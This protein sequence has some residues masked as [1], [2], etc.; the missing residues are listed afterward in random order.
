MRSG[1]KIR[2]LQA[3]PVGGSI[4]LAAVLLLLTTVPL[5]ASVSA[6]GIRDDAGSGQ[7]APNLPRAEIWIDGGHAYQGNLTGIAG[8]DSDWY[9]LDASGED[10]VDVNV[11]GALVC[12]EITD[13]TGERLDFSCSEAYQQLSQFTVELTESPFHLLHIYYNAPQHYRFAIG[14]N[15]EAT[16]PLAPGAPSLQ[17]DAGSGQDAGAGPIG[18]VPIEPGNSYQGLVTTYGDDVEDWYSFHAQAGETIQAK[19]HGAVGC[20][21]LYSPDGEEETF[22]C[23]V[24]THQFSDL[25]FTVDEAGTWY[26]SYSYFDPHPYW[27]SVALDEE[28]PDPLLPQ[29]VA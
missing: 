23:L 7:D 10:V 29:P 12:F 1:A 15:E 4:T 20:L 19:A 3:R 8:D 26:L 27:F 16:H 22:S 18:A 13:A 11:R 25:S 28:A 21:Y 9:A 24:G 17:D 2:T 14:I 5:A 6:D